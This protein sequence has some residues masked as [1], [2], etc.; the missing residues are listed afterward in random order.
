[1]FSQ[2]KLSKFVSHCHGNV[3]ITQFGTFPSSVLHQR[4][5]FWEQL[6]SGNVGCDGEEEETQRLRVFECVKYWRIEKE[7]DL[8]HW[9]ICTIVL[10][11]VMCMWFSSFLFCLFQNVWITSQKI[12]QWYKVRLP[13]RDSVNAHV[14]VFYTEL[15]STLKPFTRSDTPYISL[16][17]NIFINHFFTH[18]HP[19]KIQ[20][21]CSELIL[22]HISRF[23]SSTV[24]ISPQL[25]THPS[26]T[27]KL[28][29]STQYLP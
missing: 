15:N 19:R 7:S 8:D 24:R 12:I 2:S 3:E 28:L 17:C 10:V 13:S 4:E 9:S 22:L 1:M 25:N 6:L 16:S 27:S 23:Q 14:K 26:W 5:G 18:N 11:H 20:V 21:S 29:H